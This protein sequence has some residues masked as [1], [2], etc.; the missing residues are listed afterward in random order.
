M[1]RRMNSRATT[2]ARTGRPAAREP[3]AEARRER[4]D[5]A[6][7][8]LGLQR[9]IGN[10]ATAGLLARQPPTPTGA[11]ASTTTPQTK[12]SA[13]SAVTEKIYGPLHRGGDITAD[14]IED[15]LRELLEHRGHASEIRKSYQSQYKLDLD[16]DLERLGSANA[17]RARDYLDHGRLRTMSKLLIALAGAG[18]DLPTVYRVLAD[19]HREGDP[20]GEWLKV[21]HDDRNKLAESFRSESLEA[22]LDDDLD[23]WE[24]VKGIAIFNHGELRAIDKVFIAMDQSGTDEALLFEGLAGCDDAK[25]ERDFASYAYRK[26]SAMAIGSSLFDVLSD[27]LSGEDYKR[28]LALIGYEVDPD[29]WFAGAKDV[30]KLRTSKLVAIVK[31]A[32][33]GVGTNT[34][35]IWDAVG[36]A[37]EDE[38]AELRKLVQDPKDPLGLAGLT[39]DLSAGELARLRAMLGVAEGADAAGLSSVRDPKLLTDPAVRMLRSLGGV[40]SSTAF[41]TL[42]LSSGKALELFKAQYDTKDSPF[43]QYLSDTCTG[44]EER[45]LPVI[46]SGTVR[47][48]MGWAIRGSVSDD[49]D[50]LF[51]VVEKLASDEERRSVAGD[52]PF[53]ERFKS[54]LSSSEYAR[55]TDLLRPSNETPAEKARALDKATKQAHSGVFDAFSSTGAAVQDENRELQAGLVTAGLDAKLTPEEQRQLADAA[56]RTE[57]ALK[58]Y[59]AARDAFQETASMVVN[60]AVG[61]LATALTAGAAGPIVAAQLARAAVAM[62]LARVL[63]EK[64]I[65]GD[66]FDVFGADGAVAFAAGATD[67]VMNVVGGVAARGVVTAGLEGVGVTAA[68][69]ARSTYAKAGVHGIQQLTEGALGGGAGGLVDSLARDETWRE[70]LGP[71]VETALRAAATGAGQGAAVSGALALGGAV[72]K[73][74]VGPDGKPLPGTASVRPPEQWKA[75]REALGDLGQRVPIVE[76]PKLETTTVRVRYGD[77]T[78]VRLEVGP[79]ATAVHVARHVATAR[80]LLKYEGLL[81]RLLKLRDRIL[82]FLRQVPGYGTKGFEARAEVTKLNAILADLEGRE[83]AIRK[84]LDAAADASDAAAAQRQLDA[85]RTEMDSIDEQLRKHEAD[86]DS[87][88]PGEGFVAAQGVGASGPPKDYKTEIRINPRKEGGQWVGLPDP[89]VGEVLIFPGGQKVWRMRDGSIGVESTLGPSPGRAGHERSLPS[90]GAY[91]DPRFQEAL[92]ELTHSQGQGT[93]FESPYGIRLAPQVVNQRLQRYGIEEWLYK[94]RDEGHLPRGGKVEIVTWTKSV[95]LSNELASIEYR[96]D[97]TIDGRRMEAFGFEIAV[98]APGPPPRVRVKDPWVSPTPDYEIADLVSRVDMSEAQATI[99]RRIE[100]GAPWAGVSFSAQPGR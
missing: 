64:A 16:E 28:A 39:G 12:I 89:K 23:G 50:Y 98:E 40:D 80:F 4:R 81:G 14:K 35:L 66:R 72:A 63:S 96:I 95:P 46:V 94:I 71:G 18:T 69:V 49:E 86:V 61:F 55:L 17:V 99:Q 10:R 30:R 1:V 97:F 47:Q 93:G 70:G 36:K 7:A 65:R 77:G 6:A 38:K 9:R 41:D 90:R 52:L 26:Y 76:N 82:T 62:A 83:T 53:M 37:T 48:R 32:L 24:L 43:R 22:A 88:A 3:G 75:M 27:E 58:D 91:D 45:S 44:E 34:A 78:G 29:A 85:L 57:A 19:A 42:R 100:A 84:Q 92:Y 74:G 51:H 21:V 25:V 60:L 11:P 87:Y 68:Q 73:G 79:A 2:A 31:A 8:V 20:G 67:G 5:L 54:A 59:V 13:V 15:I 33:A 56:R